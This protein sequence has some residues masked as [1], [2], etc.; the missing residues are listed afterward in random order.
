MALDKQVRHLGMRSAPRWIRTSIAV[1]MLIGVG[2]LAVNVAKDSVPA[3]HTF[4]APAVPSVQ[5]SERSATAM[6]EQ[7]LTT[8]EFL[9]RDVNAKISVPVPSPRE[10]RPELGI[11]T[12]CTFN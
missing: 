12:D 1:L 5:A 8:Q 6:P 11:V 2:L 7:R 3:L 10:C 4:A 9:A